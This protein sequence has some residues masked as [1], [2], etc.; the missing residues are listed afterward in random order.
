V[1]HEVGKQLTAEPTLKSHWDCS[2]LSRGPHELSRLALAGM[3][4]VDRPAD[5]PNA[6]LALQEFSGS[7]TVRFTPAELLSAFDRRISYG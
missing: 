1:Y 3:K 4:S 5:A 7:F 6:A 2:W